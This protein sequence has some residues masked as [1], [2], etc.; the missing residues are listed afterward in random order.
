MLC[1]RNPIDSW[2][3][4]RVVLL[5]DAAHPMLQYA[6]QGACQALEDA[7]TLGGCL[8][9]S[10]GQDPSAGIVKYVAST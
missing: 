6:A 5:G 3:S 7:I 10:E 2:A 4:D 8:R 1:D 9:D